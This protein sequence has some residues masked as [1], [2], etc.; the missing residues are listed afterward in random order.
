VGLVLYFVR[1]SFVGVL[2]LA[3]FFLCFSCVVCFFFCLVF[4][5]GGGGCG[6][7]FFFFFFFGV[8]FFFVSAVYF[9][10][11]LVPHHQF[12]KLLASAVPPSNP[13]FHAGFPIVQRLRA[14]FTTLFLFI[15]AFLPMLLADYDAFSPCESRPRDY[16]SFLCPSP[17]FGLGI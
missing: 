13:L 14:P 8:G 11:F 3:F 12:R 2:F 5:C 9:F 10:F 6:F 4:V 17:F 7:F 15:A 16:L 1:C